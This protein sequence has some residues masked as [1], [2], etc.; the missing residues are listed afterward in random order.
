MRDISLAP[1]AVRPANIS[2]IHPQLRDLILPVKQGHVLYPHGTAIEEQK[3]HSD[4]PTGGKTSMLY[5][6]SFTPSC[7]TTQ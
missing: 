6:L 4:D 2:I 1:S 5:K 3:W 7:L